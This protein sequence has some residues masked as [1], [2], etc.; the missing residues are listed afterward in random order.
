MVSYE[1][2]DIVYHDEYVDE[3][4]YLDHNNKDGSNLP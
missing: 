2:E 3:N 1:F 4:G